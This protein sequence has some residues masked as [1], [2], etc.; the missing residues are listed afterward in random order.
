MNNIIP[1]HPK[2]P[3]KKF[4]VLFDVRHFNGAVEI[5]ATNEAEARLKFD[6]IAAD[7][8]IEHTDDLAV[9]VEEIEKVA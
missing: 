1:L 7:K 9:E 6:Q 5:E 3:T 8:L 4:R 2:P